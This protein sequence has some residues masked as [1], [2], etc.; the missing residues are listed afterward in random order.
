MLPHVLIIL[1]KTLG[2]IIGAVGGI[3][4]L[5]IILLEIWC[6]RMDKHGINNPFA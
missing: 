6:W 4:A 1:L 5:F 2:I 3:I